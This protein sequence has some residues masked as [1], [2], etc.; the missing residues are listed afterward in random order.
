LLPAQKLRR[1]VD[2]ENCEQVAYN[3]QVLPQF[4][5]FVFH[6]DGTTADT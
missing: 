1:I 6:H 5:Y 3:E 2:A 4:G